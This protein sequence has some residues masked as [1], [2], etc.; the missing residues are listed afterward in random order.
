MNNILDYICWRGDVPLE[1]SPFNEIDSLILSQLSYLDFNNLLD[2]NFLNPIPLSE[3]AVNFANSSD[4]EK[5]S[6]NLGL[7]NKSTIQLLIAAGNSVRFGNIKMCAYI[8]STDFS[9]EEQFCAVSFVLNKKQ[10]YLAFR[11]TDGSLVGWKEDFNMAFM[12]PVPAQQSAVE[13]MNNACQTLKGEIILGGHSKGGN[14]AI[15]A[16]AFCLPKN[17]K[18]IK[19]IFNY[20]GPGFERTILE[21]PEFQAILPLICTYMPQSSVVGILFEH[22]ENCVLVESSKNVGVFQHDPF[23]WFVYGN[24]FVTVDSLTTDSIFINI[25]I[26][27]WLEQLDKSKREQFIDTLFEVL[28]ATHVE[29]LS[30]L[31][32]SWVKNARLIIKALA[33]I[34][35]E[36]REAVLQ[37]FHLLFK[38]AQTTVP[39]IVELSPHFK[40][41]LS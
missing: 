2:E 4:F 14:L 31:S 33:H 29:T 9:K 6:E 21:K 18:R 35:P 32:D 23:T 11:G 10:N 8:K 27:K 39:T 34:E 28:N 22:Y 38:T 16:S 37:T 41:L 3:V 5:R 24:A 1:V 12:S 36:T 7:V 26:K 20:D 15:Y 40:N 17:Q 13:Y 25:T 19:S 30:D